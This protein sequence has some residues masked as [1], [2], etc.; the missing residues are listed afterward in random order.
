[1]TVNS[2]K[3]KLFLVTLLL[4]PASLLA[5]GNMIDQQPIEM[6]IAL[7]NTENKLRFFPSTLEF[8]T[9][10]LYKLVIKNP[11]TQKHYF[12][13]EELSR[14]VFTRKVQVV[15]KSNKT[16]AEVKGHI[17][18]IEVYPGG[19]TEWWFVPVKTLTSSR[20][21]CSIKGHSEAGMTGQ[22]TIK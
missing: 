19:T 8:E 16:L 1:M 18:E 11:S 4:F 2:N 7:G 13:A 3:I 14:S 21:H 20:L 10:K 15:N 9:G 17:N 6:T 5:A 12:T 22:I